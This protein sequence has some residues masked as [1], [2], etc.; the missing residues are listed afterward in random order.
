MLFK[1][2][3]LYIIVITLLFMVWCII[4]IS[5][6]KNLQ[7]QKQSKEKISILYSDTEDYEIYSV[8][9]ISYQTINCENAINVLFSQKDDL[10]IKTEA[11]ETGYVQSEA[12]DY[13]QFDDYSLVYNS[14]GYEEVYDSFQKNKVQKYSLDNR[15][16]FGNAEE[17]YAQIGLF[18]S[19]IDIPVDE[20][21]YSCYVIRE[22]EKSGV[23]NQEYYYFLIWQTVNGYPMISNYFG[24]DINS[25]SNVVPINIIYSEKGFE[26]IHINQL[27]SLQIENKQN[28][29][30]SLDEIVAKIE[31]KYNQLL[32][33]AAYYSNRVYLGY[34]ILDIPE[35]KKTAIPV[36]ITYITENYNVETYQYLEIY[37]ALS[38]EEIVL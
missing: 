27:Y 12:G 24:N 5:E 17:I 37:N 10:D 34:L 36:W 32:N 14:A 11:E 16:S 4:S 31:F 7:G 29:I 3:A 13:L 23:N 21:S 1:K 30:L 22:N 38:G 6:P 20:L 33:G 25:E 15:L 28:D 35:K 18:L 8:E 26:Y 2:K 19:S 9:K